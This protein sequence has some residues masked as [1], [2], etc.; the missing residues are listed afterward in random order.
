[1]NG[2]R[3]EKDYFNPILCRTIDLHRQCAG[4]TG[5]FDV[6]DA[7]SSMVTVTENNGFLSFS[8][9]LTANLYTGLNVYNFTLGDNQSQEINFLP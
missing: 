4:N 5:F 8:S 2:E 9:T 3:N 1:M 6:A 7:P